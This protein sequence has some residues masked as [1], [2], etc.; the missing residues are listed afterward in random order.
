MSENQCKVDSYSHEGKAHKEVGIFS[1]LTTQVCRLCFKKETIEKS[2]KTSW[3]Y[4]NPWRMMVLII[5]K[6]T[7]KVRWLKK[8][9][10]VTK[11]HKISERCGTKSTIDNKGGCWQKNQWKR[12]WRWDMLKVKCFKLWPIWSLGKGMPQATLSE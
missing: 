8:Q 10:Q 3:N 4:W 11:A 12:R 2:A 6:Q 9:T 1:K 5:I 7:L